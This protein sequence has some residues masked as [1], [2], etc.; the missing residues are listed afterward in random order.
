MNKFIDLVHSQGVN[1]W[2]ER[3]RDAFDELFGAGVGRYPDK[4]KK[5][6]S[7]RAPEFRG[8][9]GVTF[10]AIIHSSNPDSGAYGGMSLVVF[11]VE[12][13]RCLLA[14]VVGTQGL[15]PDEEVLGRPGHGRKVAAICSWLN[16][17]HGKGNMVA[18][19]T[20][21][22]VRTD[23][24]VPYNIKRFFPQYSSVFDRY[25]RVIYGIFAPTEDAEATADALKAFMDL[26]FEERGIYPL[27]SGVEEGEQIRS[28]YFA[29]LMPDITEEEVQEVLQERRFAVLQG[30]PGTGKT[31]MALR[32]LNEK[33]QGNGLSIQFHSNTTYEN[34]V[35]GLAPVHSSDAMG[36]R[37]APQPGYLMKAAKEAMQKPQE[38][39][40]LHIDEINRAD[41]A[42]VLGEAIFLL[43]PQADEQRELALP[44]DF[45]EPFKSTFYLPD[46]LHILGTMNSADRSIAIVDV[47]V[48]RRFAFDKLW[49]QM[50]VVN[51]FGGALM[52]IAFKELVSI[53]VEHAGEDA[54]ALLPGHSYFL[55]VDDGKAAR[56]L[57]LN[58]APL[59]EEYLAQGYVASFSDPIRA[60]LQW[61]ES[62]QR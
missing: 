22:P 14:M 35:G 5:F 32:I 58:L 38:P 36:F 60:Y 1:N 51:N 41:L 18:W 15:S 4:A 21:D 12:Q 46:N 33:Y 37:F 52:Q 55:E 24:D 11:P 39:Y 61:I 9:A 59:L 40:L 53:F 19:A 29:H 25:G 13:D 50:S 62:M 43:E 54:L 56:H 44:Y 34:F 31:R 2:S 48:R 27:K 8:G 7:I 57:R 17:K 49:P 47:A 3:A 26:M 16:Q 23:L 42:K 10:A 28:Q 30:P 20:L 45:G 6:V